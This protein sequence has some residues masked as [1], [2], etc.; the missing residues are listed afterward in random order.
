LAKFA[1]RINGINGTVA[2]E[3]ATKSAKRHEKVKA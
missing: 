1:G 3:I 2:R